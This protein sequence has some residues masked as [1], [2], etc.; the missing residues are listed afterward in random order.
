METPAQMCARLIAALEDLAGQEAAALDAR[1]FRGAV[2]VQDRAAPLVELLC[3]HAD[4][5]ADEAL[6]ARIAALI[7]RRNRTGEWLAEQIARVREQLRETQVAQ[8]R[9]AQ[10]APAYG[11]SVRPAAR[12][13]VAVG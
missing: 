8:R 11:Q 6:R 10:V 12:Q 7:E 4:D 13:L 3:A 1:D 9:V 5:V 2:T